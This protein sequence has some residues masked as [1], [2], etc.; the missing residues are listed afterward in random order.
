MTDLVTGFY[1]SLHRPATPA[2]STS[3]SCS[4]GT[5]SNNCEV[6]ELVREFKER[7][8]QNL[9]SNSPVQSYPTK[10]QRKAE[11]CSKS[12]EERKKFALMWSDERHKAS[13]EDLEASQD[14]S[15]WFGRTKAAVCLMHLDPQFWGP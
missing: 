11:V 5:M 8:L 9:L 4:V 3:L 7:G 14:V 6:Q 13:R 10:V 12:D 1:K 2:L 15:S